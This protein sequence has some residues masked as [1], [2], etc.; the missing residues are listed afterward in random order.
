[1]VAHEKKDIK[2]Q[3]V[4]MDTLKDHSMPHMAEKQSAREMFKALVDLF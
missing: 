4:N 2:A 3:R 1:M